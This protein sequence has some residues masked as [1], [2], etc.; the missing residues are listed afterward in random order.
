MIHLPPDSDCER[1]VSD[2]LA[3][4][5][6]E[7]KA[8]QLAVV[9][10]PDPQDRAETEAFARAIRDGRVTAVEG[11]GSKLQAEAFQQIAIEESRLGIPLLFPA[12][13]ATGIDTIFPAPLA[14]AASFDMDAIAA[15]EGVVADEAHSRGVNWALGPEAGYL[16]PSSGTGHPSSAEQV[17][18]AARIAAARVRGLQAAGD[19]AREGVL[20]CLDLSRILAP[21]STGGRQEIAD[22]LRI[23]AH[24][25]Q[26][27]YLGSISFGG[28]DTRHR[29]ALQRAFAF[30]QGPGAFEGIV[31]SEWQALA[32]AARDSEH[33]EIGDY[34]PIDAI[35]A[36][37][38]KREI[39]LSRL[40]DA[41]ARVLRAKYA[42]GLFSQPLG[43]EAVRRR[44]SLPTP[45][46]NRQAALDLAKKCCVLLR[47]EPAM[48]PLG[49]DSGDILVIGNA[50]NDRSLPVAG[51]GGPGAS[52]IDGLEQLGIPYKFA[53]GLALR[54]EN[55]TVG[56]LVEADS[57]AIGM[58][59]EAAK[60][61]RTV[62]VV[63]GECKN[64][65]LSEAEQQLLASLRSVTEHIV[66]VTLG[67]LPLDPVVSGNPLPAVL[68]AGQLGTMSGHAIAEILT[69]E[70][71]PCG[72]LPVAIPASE[73]NRGLP[74]GHGLNY[75]D[76]ALTDLTLGLATDHI[77]AS[78]QLRNTGEISGTETVQLFVRRYR[79]RHLPSRMDLRDFERV[80]LAPGERQTV[81]FE[82]GKEEVGEFREDGRLVAEGGT[83][84]I[85]IGL[86][87]GRTLGGEIELP[88][89]VA[90][91]MGGFVKGLPGSAADSRRRA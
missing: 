44:G 68:H 48:L 51:R 54:R 70:A 56:R 16:R 43:R 71:A 63:L 20:A 19:T 37:V 47:N 72:K 76:F 17:H 25:S 52:V 33:V 66:L 59:C 49:V 78:A 18:L 12:E 82:L 60:R 73:H 46:Q 77:V 83:L 36:A 26:Q 91:A 79:G 2:L 6:V 13:T 35:A 75:A 89:A 55:G 5:T 41:A 69:G 62:V 84:D 40:D 90:R 29:G 22:A 86:S 8:G 27:G 53:P 85:R 28:A 64:A 11:I 31:L 81:R 34:M 7:E 39:P 38:E 10:A 24:V 67:T 88:E 80:T 74:F 21:A 57:M 58:A 61:S 65:R 23:A 42:L 45:I 4:M 1:V 87:A 30:L 15:A 14:A 3:Y 9:Q 50:A 32:A